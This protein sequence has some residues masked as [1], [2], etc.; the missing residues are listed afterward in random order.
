MEYIYYRVYDSDGDRIFEG[1]LELA[2]LVF[3]H[4]DNGP[5]ILQKVTEI[6]QNVIL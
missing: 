3:D 1:T 6:R 2:K 4:C 5:C